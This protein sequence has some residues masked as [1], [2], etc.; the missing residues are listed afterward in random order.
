MEPDLVEQPGVLS[1]LTQLYIDTWSPDPNFKEFFICPECHA[2]YSFEDVAVRKIR[3]CPTDG[4]Q[5]DRAW[6]FDSVQSMILED[7]QADG[8]YGTLVMAPNPNPKPDAPE[9]IVVG[10]AW[11]FDRTFANIRRSWGNRVAKD[12]L[13]LYDRW[14]NEATEVVPYFSEIGLD[15]RYRGQG[16]G[17]ALA[18]YIC[19]HMVAEYPNQMSLLRTHLH[20]DAHELY[21]DLG[22]ADVS[23][24]TQFGAGRVLMA[25]YPTTRF[26][27]R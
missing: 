12:L 15:P 22:Y 4:H 23:T 27:I 7:M 18:N 26:N 19:G 1:M 5:L 21:L 20:S 16:L 6:K 3:H 14:V 10:F 25:I 11:S 9:E 2:Y 8:F 17:R 13:E 24:D